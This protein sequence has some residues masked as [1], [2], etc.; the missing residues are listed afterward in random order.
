[1]ELWELRISKG[2]GR[3]DKIGEYICW[4]GVGVS[5][6]GGVRGADMGTV[7]SIDEVLLGGVAV[8]G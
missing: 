4:L 8:N 3:W 5:G 1:M 6:V 2:S 7:H